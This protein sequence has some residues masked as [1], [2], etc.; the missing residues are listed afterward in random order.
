MGDSDFWLKFFLREDE[1]LPATTGDLLNHL[2]PNDGKPMAIE[3][4][5][6]YEAL[7]QDQDE[8][9][10]ADY[11][12]FLAYMKVFKQ[13]PEA[14]DAFYNTLLMGKLILM[15]PENLNTLFK[16]YGVRSSFKNASGRIMTDELVLDIHTKD[17]TWGVNTYGTDADVFIEVYKNNKKIQSKKLDIPL[18]NDF[19]MGD[20]D[21][22]TVSLGERVP[23]EQLS[24]ALHIERGT[25]GIDEWTPDKIDITC[26]CVDIDVLPKQTILN[27]AYTFDTSGK[28]KKWLYINTS[29]ITLTYTS[30]LNPQIISY[31]M[32]NDNS[33]Q[34]VNDKNLLWSNMTARRN[35]LYKVFKG[36]E[37]EIKLTADN[38]T[39]MQGTKVNLTGDFTSYWNGITK[40]RRDKEKDLN[41]T[42]HET[43]QQACNGTVKIM[44]VSTTPKQILTGKVTNGKM[45]VD[46]STLAPGTYK[47][48]ADYD[49][50]AFNGSAQSNIVTIT[51]TGTPVATHT[52]TY[53]VV[54]GTWADGST[55][56]K[57]ETVVNG[58]SP[59]N[60]P[61]GMIPNTGFTGGSWNVNPSAA[62]ITGD[63]T[64]TY[65][66][67]SVPVSTYNVTYK[68]VNGTWADGST[69]D[70]VENVTNGSSPVN[71][72]TGMIA[73]SG[74]TGGSWNIEP[75]S[76]TITG[77]ITFTF[78]FTPATGKTTYYTY[79]GSGQNYVKDSGED[80]QFS[81][82]RSV[83][84][85]KTFSLFT[86]IQVDG[87][88]VDKSQYNAQAGSVIITLKSSYLNTLSVGDHLMTVLFTDGKNDIPFTVTAKAKPM[89]PTNFNDV[90]VPSDSFT[91]KKVWQ[92]DSEKSIDF[93]LYKA[94]GTVYHHGFDKKI[95]SNREWRYNAWFSSPA[96]CYVVEKPI[97]GY[98]TKYVNVGVYAQITDRC[99]DGGTIINKKIPKTGDTAD[100]ALWAGLMLAG[101]AGLT[102]LVLVKKRRKAEK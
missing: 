76:A 33:T 95:V 43:L 1:S 7:K 74:F 9:P 26:R 75:V 51:V 10:Y 17:G 94:D 71:V 12:E 67:A 46:L 91:F 44:D 86:G 101:I 3:A 55:T 21:T 42:V 58:S 80:K 5:K 70:K 49:G 35:I 64:F 40:E 98:Q 63:T 30:A 50:D 32:S 87:K 66:F 89:D 53:K 18:Y 100:L 48:R 77:D 11:N 37:P 69:V 34:W 72:P 84:D 78:T 15:G 41:K 96:A 29:G 68:V 47:L 36:F 90:A 31:M 65:A 60:V 24:V 20:L 82:K 16:K 6:Q 2:K 99:C 39:F 102:T 45:N 13:D 57:A 59:S 62:I 27:S 23:V 88:N 38:T 93:T 19:E 79:S 73:S 28:T 8:N 83:D 14:L 56:D 81:V 85:D 25:Y 61:T 54:D 92:G 4:L 52:V 97:P 22:Y